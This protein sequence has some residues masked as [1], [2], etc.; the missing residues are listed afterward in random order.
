ML[1]KHEGFLFVMCVCVDFQGVSHEDHLLS[2]GLLAHSL[3]YLLS[4][5]PKGLLL[6]A[7]DAKVR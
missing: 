4:S 2:S 6:G 7:R 5:Y 1:H 3:T